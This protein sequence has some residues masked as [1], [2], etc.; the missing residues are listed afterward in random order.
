M[1]IHRTQL[2]CSEEEFR[3][4]LAAYQVA[5]DAA[6]KVAGSPAPFPKYEMI[7][8]LVERGESFEV[9]EEST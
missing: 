2:P 1:I 5:K 9:V 6:N 3:A 8:V 4:E 7:R